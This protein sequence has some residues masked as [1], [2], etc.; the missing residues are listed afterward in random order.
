MPGRRRKDRPTTDAAELVQ[1]HIEERNYLLFTLSDR[2]P[3]RLRELNTWSLEGLYQFLY[4]NSIH[5][6]RIQDAQKTAKEASQGKRR[7]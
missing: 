4:A 3:V 2:D 6:R 1:R 7:G 5:S